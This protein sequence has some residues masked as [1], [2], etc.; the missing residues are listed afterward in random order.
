MRG[1]VI[2]GCGLTLAYDDTGLMTAVGYPQLEEK[3]EGRMFL[4]PERG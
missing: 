4:V 2:S 3:N 1:L